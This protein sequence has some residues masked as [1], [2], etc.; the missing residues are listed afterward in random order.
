MH[1]D[2][3]LAVEIPGQPQAVGLGAHVAQGRLGRL[4][5]HLAQLAGDEELAPARHDHHFGLQEFAAELGPGQPGGE[6]HFVLLL[7][8]AEAELGHPQVLGDVPG[9]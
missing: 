7:G 4:L 1:V 9:C 5:H 8:A 2:V 3:D 6:A